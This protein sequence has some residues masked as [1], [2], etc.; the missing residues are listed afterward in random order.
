MAQS[1]D[2]A[3]WIELLKQ[4]QRKYRYITEIQRITKELGDALS[5]NDRVAAELLLVMRKDEMTGADQCDRNIML[6]RESLH[7][8]ERELLEACLRGQKELLP[9]DDKG[10]QWLEKLY[11]IQAKIRSILQ[12][13]IERDKVMN[14]KIAGDNSFYAGQ[15]GKAPRI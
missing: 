6:L 10:R 1:I 2:E 8:E 13:T 5:R 15:A 9:E 14:R 12:D 7:A 4:Y 11:D 3:L